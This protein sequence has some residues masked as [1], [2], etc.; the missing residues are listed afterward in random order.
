[1]KKFLIY[2]FFFVGFI[3][4]IIY[5]NVGKI[6]L[7]IGVIAVIIT[8]VERKAEV[9]D[10][11]S[12][13]IRNA[14]G[15]GD[16]IISATKE[17]LEKSKAPSLEIREEKVGPGLTSVIIGETRD[18]LIVTDRRNIKLSS[19]KAYINANNYGDCL[20]ISWYLTY[21]PDI[22]Q[23][24]FSLLPGARQILNLDDLNLFNRQDLTAYV[25]NAHHCLLEAVDKLMLGMGQDPSKIDRK[26][27][28]FLGI[29]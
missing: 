20:F 11:W 4:L 16:K 8:I 19:F 26:S 15:Q 2:C 13:L 28:G 9:L 17:L 23:A 10:N 27:K 25:T 5:P 22:S 3:F 1:M 24:L 29:S 7:A 14:Q 12:A 21:L 18:F 6:L